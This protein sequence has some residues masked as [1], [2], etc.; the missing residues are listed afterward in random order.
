MF[1]GNTKKGNSSRDNRQSGRVPRSVS[2]DPGAATA[3]AS[4]GLPGRP[5]LRPALLR[6]PDRPRS[7]TPRPSSSHL[8][9]TRVQ[10]PLD[11]PK[12]PS[13]LE[14]DKANPGGLKQV[15]EAPR[16]ETSRLCPF[17]FQRPFSTPPL[18]ASFAVKGRPA[19]KGSVRSPVTVARIGH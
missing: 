15:P 13:C 11:L 7:H 2:G 12:D 4:G 18:P 8:G 14:E 10:P 3:S 5:V 9:R 19:R 1:S 17:D 6:G 16:T